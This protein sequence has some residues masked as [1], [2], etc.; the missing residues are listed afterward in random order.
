MK[1]TIFVVSDVHGY[2][3]I[4]KQALDEAGFRP[5]DP[6]HLLLCLGDVIDRG[7]QNKQV[8]TYFE[9]LQ[10]CVLIRGN[11]ETMLQKLLYTGKVEPHHRINGTVNTLE[12]F[13]GKYAFNLADET[14][15]FSGKTRVVDRLCDFI[16]DTVRY[17]ETKNFV[18]VHGWLPSG[19]KDASQLPSYCD[20][21]WDEA[22]KKKWIHHYKGEPPLN[23]KTLVVGHVP[24]FYASAVDPRWSK[25]CS[26]IY[27]GQGM[28]AI[29]AGTHDTKRVNLLVIEDELI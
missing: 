29:D 4:M 20:S 26:N 10:N 2:F 1:K 22:S 23:F 7:N 11:H 5:N 14:L 9:R 12:D 21:T 3:S 17:Y 18:F 28:I 15:D 19:C 16:Y 27:Y 8:V 25:D 13:F 6:Q 24:T